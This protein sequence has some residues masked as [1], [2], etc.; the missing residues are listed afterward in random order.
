MAFSDSGDE[1]RRGPGEGLLVG[2][3]GP[4]CADRRMGRVR[5]LSPWHPPRSS[6]EY[7]KLATT[8][9]LSARKDGDADAALAARR[10]ILEAAYEFPYLAHASDGAD[11]LRGAARK[12]AVA[13]SGTAS[14]SRP[15]TRRWWPKLLGLN[16]GAGERSTSSTPAAASAGAPIPSPTTCSR[17]PR[18]AK[19]I[20]GAAPVKLVW[21]R[22]DDMRAGFYRPMYYHTLKAGLDAQ[23]NLV[24]WQH[25]SSASRS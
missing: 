19:A 17:P 18:I 9:G 3:E 14:S 24:A 1:R 10:K 23:G 21:G 15:S 25:A 22:E 6:N 7:K 4:R 13:R 20:N 5:R 12:A 2:E 16:A 8:P 11:E